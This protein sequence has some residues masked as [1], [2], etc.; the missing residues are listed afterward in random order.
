MRWQGAA[1]LV[2]IV[3]L[4]RVVFAQ[5]ILGSDPAS[6]K[7]LDLAGKPC[8]ESSGSATPLASNPRIQNHLVSLNN[9][10]PNPIKAKVCYYKTDEC[11]DVDVP[12]HSRREQVLGVF[13]AI[14]LFRYEVKEQF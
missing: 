3:F 14:Q 1:V 8:L 13:P 10:C 9:H 7:H 11:M 12:G 6:G 4:S 5:G 2:P